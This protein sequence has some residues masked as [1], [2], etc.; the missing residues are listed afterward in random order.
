M[1]SFGRLHLFR[2]SCIGFAFVRCVEPLPLLEGLAVFKH[3]WALLVVLSPLPLLEGK[4]CF[5]WLRW[6]VVHVFGDQV[7]LSAH[8]KWPS[9]TFSLAFGHLGEFSVF[10]FFF[11]FFFFFFFLL[12][13]VCWCWQCT[14]QGGY[15]KHKVDICPCGPDLWWLIVNVICVLG[16][17]CELTMAWV[18]LCNMSL[19]LW[20]VGVELGGGG[21]WWAEG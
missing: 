20:C 13:F 4:L 16:W 21:R 11:F 3:F 7:L 19:G 12:A 17:V 18:G 5:S 14:H 8:F 15:C 1:H 10:L 2:E 9:F 6:A